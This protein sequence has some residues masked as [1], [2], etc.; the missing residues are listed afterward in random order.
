MKKV[1]L[2]SL[3]FLL[4]FVGTAGL[5]AETATMKFKVYG[6]CEMCQ[7]RIEKAALSVDGVS[8]ASWNK[9]TKIIEVTFDNAKTDVHKIHQAI[10]KA[11]HD[12]QMHKAKDEDYNKLSG[13]CKYKRNGDKSSMNSHENHE[14]H[15][16]SGCTRDKSAKTSS[17]CKK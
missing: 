17:C 14:N 12:T 6:N 9:E 7:D 1:K 2:I 11:G 10:A 4:F 8:K 15:N 3:V 16:H 13:C 5:I